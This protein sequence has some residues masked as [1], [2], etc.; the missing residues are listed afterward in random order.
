VVRAA[1]VYGPGDFNWNRIV[2]GTIRSLLRGESPLIRSDGTLERDYLYLDDVVS[3]YL[4]VSDHLPEVAGQAFNLGTEAPISVLAMIE[5]I[6]EIVGGS[7]IEPKILGVAANEIDRQ[8]LAFTKAFETLGW[9]PRIDLAEGL[10]RT[11]AW[12]AWH[13]ASQ[14]ETPITDTRIEEGLR[15]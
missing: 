3:G 14:A 15:A 8:S 13:L 1:N 5:N 11:V 6:I 2:P 12:Y 7:R 10:R 4:A 9:Q